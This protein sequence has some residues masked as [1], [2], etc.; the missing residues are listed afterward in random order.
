MP[1]PQMLF[2]NRYRIEDM[3]DLSGKVAVVTGGSRGI[4]EAVTHALVQKGAH[5][6]ILS[7]T[8]D[9]AKAAVEHITPAVP[10]A[11]SQTTIHTV[12]LGHLASVLAVGRELAALPRI[13]L[14][15]LIAGVGVGPFG[16]TQDGLGNHYQVNV[17]A[18]HL[19]ADV[20]A[21]KLK[22][23]A[24]AKQG[25]DEAER[26]STRIVSESS[27]LHR[28]APSDIK[29]TLE[30]MNT[31]IGP[32]KLYNRSKLFDIYFIRE[33]ARRLP[34]LDSPSPVLALSVHPGGVATEQE[35]SATEAYGPV[36]GGVLETAA[37]LLFKSKE[38]GA[39]STLWAGTGHSV[40]GRREEVQGRYF[41][42]PDGK[43]GTETYQAEDEAA[44]R[45]LWELNVRVLKDKLGY[46][47]KL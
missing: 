1:S 42:E 16:L 15:F 4:G 6:H 26:F 38:E 25:A 36:I 32:A 9:H 45:K 13:D 30:E 5:V 46:D 43:V 27:D 10:N 24:Q 7:A 12:D 41:T 29:F 17:L 18:H 23:T 28:G 39:E 35:H 37:Q 22:E 20:L 33:L 11:S 47:A 44:A 2:N 31:D 3:P 14:L 34:S 8:E 19:L 21:P 40:V